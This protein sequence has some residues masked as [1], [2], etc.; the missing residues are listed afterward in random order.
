M[1]QITLTQGQYAIVDDWNY[2]WLNQWKW[3]AGWAKNTKS[4]YAMR[5]AKGEF[6]RYYTIRMHREILGLKKGD[7]RQADHINHNTLDNRESNLRIVN[8]QQNCFN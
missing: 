5:R 8:N 4:Y 2:E 3:C 6:D 1:K 7:R